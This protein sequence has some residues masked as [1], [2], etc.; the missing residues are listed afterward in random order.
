MVF[1]RAPVSLFFIVA[2]T[3]GSII[4]REAQQNFTN[5]NFIGCINEPASGSHALTKRW[6]SSGMSQQLCLNKAI[7]YR[8]AGIEG[9]VQCWFGNEIN[10]LAI[11]AGL[12]SS[13]N[14]ECPGNSAEACG[15]ELS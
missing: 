13:C 6:T 8:Y 2:L 4:P 10:K 14:L 1:I 12:N 11:P 7:G 15:G 5:W 9:G 3:Y